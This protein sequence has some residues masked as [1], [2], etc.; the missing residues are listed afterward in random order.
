MTVKYI[1]SNSTIFN[2]SGEEY[3]LKGEQNPFFS[4]HKILKKDTVFSIDDYPELELLLLSGILNNNAEII[5]D[6]YKTEKKRIIGSPTEG[7]ILFLA[8][9]IGIDYRKERL[10]NKIIENFPFNSEVKR[11]T[12]I[13][14]EGADFIAYTKGASELILPRCNSIFLNEK[15]L[16]LNDKIRKDIEDS[17]NYL[18]KKGLRILSLSFR[19]LKENEK[20]EMSRDEVE[21]DMVYIGF[22]C[23]SDP[24]RLGVRKAVKTCEDAGIKVVMI[25]GDSEVTA[26]NIAKELGILVSGEIVVKGSQIDNLEFQNFEKITVFARVTPKDKQTIVDRYQSRTN[27]VVAMTG[28][29]VNDA[30]ALSMADVGISMGISGTDVAKESSDIIINDDNFVTIKEGILQGR[31]LFNKI[32]SI[33]Y[34]YL[35]VNILEA[36]IFFGASFFPN[37][38]LFSYWQLTM[39]Y[40]TAHS[41]PPLALVLDRLD[42]NV[43]KDKP[44][45]SEEILTKHIFLMMIIHAFLMAIGIVT[46]YVITISGVI[47]IIP[48][49][50]GGILSVNISLNQQK[51]QTMSMSVILITETLLVFSIR[52]LNSSFFKNVIQNFSVF[53]PITIG[54]VFAGWFLLL[55]FPITQTILASAGFTLEWMSL[56]L[57]DWVFVILFSL[58]GIVG[59]EIIRYLFRKNNI[60]F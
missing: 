52:R 50:L 51:A 7:A 40:L 60:K 54:L 10:K 5:S 11:M 45:D 19:Y 14:P 16:E 20:F 41:L 26:Q 1:W 43:M 56:G 57:T 18:A 34:F 13:F 27:R 24:L 8:D 42:K 37:F 46:I 3:D 32:R 44:R 6:K 31:S 15:I 58:P 39:L 25:T 30:L 36:S 35:V 38:D 55:Y 28:D 53:F 12:T 2:V 33:V 48:E 59:F 17:I 49:N 21:R 4:S 29:G 9:E 47:P 23:I 22:V